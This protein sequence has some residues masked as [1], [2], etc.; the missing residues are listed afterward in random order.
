[1]NGNVVRIQPP[2]IISEDEIARVL[3]ILERAIASVN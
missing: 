1:V 3:A 2:L